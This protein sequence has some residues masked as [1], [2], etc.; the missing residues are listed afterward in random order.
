MKVCLDTNVLVAAF[1]T[2]GLCADVLRAVLAEHELVTGEVILAE[3]R[4]TLTTK[5]MAPADRVAM[6][7]ASLSAFPVLPKPRRRRPWRSAITLIDGFSRPPSPA[8]PMCLSRAIGICSPL[9]TYRPSVFLRRAPFGICSARPNRARR[10]KR[11]DGA[12]FAMRVT[13][14][15]VA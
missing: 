11:T 6:A 10:R 2:R 7:E 8:P 13:S 3:F 15:A 5:L 14:Y 1:A 9:L 4:R 12:A